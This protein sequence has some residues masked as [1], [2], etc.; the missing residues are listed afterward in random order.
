M[1]RPADNRR[2]QAVVEASPDAVIQADRRGFIVGWSARAGSIFC[3]PASSAI[4]RPLHELIIPARARQAHLEG[5]QRYLQ[6]GEARVRNT[7]LELEALHRD[8]HEF[9]VELTVTKAQPE[10]EVKF[11]AFLRDISSRRREE[12]QCRAT[13]TQLQES[14]RLE[15][16]GT[17]AAGIA[18][19]FNNIVA[20]IL[21]HATLIGDALRPQQAARGHL[22]HITRAAERARMLVR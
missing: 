22:L 21:G 10:N 20:A 16:I 9:P 5:T 1:S 8:G 17:F 18:H 7:T 12:V 4:G 3:W 13:E 19:D 15:M 11:T 14:R 2:Y 6:T